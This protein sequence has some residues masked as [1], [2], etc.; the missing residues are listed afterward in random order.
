MGEV[1]IEALLA[2]AYLD[3]FKISI[4][5]LPEPNG[6]LKAPNKLVYPDFNTYLRP[7]SE[8]T[9]IA[10]QARSVHRGPKGQMTPKP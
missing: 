6:K 1:A 3:C 5:G 2:E 9:D 4:A 10:Y 8:E 7:W